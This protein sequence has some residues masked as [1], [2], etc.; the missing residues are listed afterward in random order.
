MINLQIELPIPSTEE[1]EPE[2]PEPTNPEYYELTQARRLNNNR[3]FNPTERYRL[4]AF[5]EEKYIPSKGV[6][7]LDLPT[8]IMTKI[9]RHVL[10]YPHDLWPWQYSPRPEVRRISGPPPQVDLF[11]VF[12]TRE[13][14]YARRAFDAAK[15]VFYQN[16]KF[17]Y[18][19]SAHKV[20]H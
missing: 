19:T 16:N 7:L 4:L 17:R 6:Q 15:N 5:L 18:A 9:F 8:H 10:I 2:V 11:E 3:S 14:K 12:C 1:I 13:N 20:C